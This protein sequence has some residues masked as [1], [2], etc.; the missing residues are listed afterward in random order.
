MPNEEEKAR[1]GN[2]GRERER[3]KGKRRARKRGRKTQK[4]KNIGQYGTIR[5]IS[6]NMEGVL[7]KSSE[8]IMLWERPENTKALD[9]P[10]R[11]GSLLH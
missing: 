11:E 8:A 2:R 6:I 9:N 3:K 7:T 4:R 1:D 10:G 5:A